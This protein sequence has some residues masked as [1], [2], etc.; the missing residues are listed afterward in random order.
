MWGGSLA[1]PRVVPGK[2]QVRLSVDGKVIATEPFAIKADPRLATTQDDFAKQFD[3]MVKIN[4]KLSEMN[5]CILEIRDIRTQLESLSARL[6]MPENKDLSDKSKEIVRS[7]TEIE[8]ALYQ[9]KIKSGQD[10]L[11]FPIRLNNKLAALSSYVDGSD[12]GPTAQSYLVYDYLTEQIDVQLGR[13]AK[14]KSESL[15][16]FNKQYLAKGLPVVTTK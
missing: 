3:L 16:D 1:G 11:N 2:Y 14:T 5:G 9:T 13:F 4:K 7:L 6:K 10:A 12:D 15:A 8:E